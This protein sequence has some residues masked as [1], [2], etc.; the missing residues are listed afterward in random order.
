MR[1]LFCDFSRRFCTVTPTFCHVLLG[2]V[3]CPL[4]EVCGLHRATCLGFVVQRLPRGQGLCKSSTEVA[5]RRTFSVYTRSR[6]CRWLQQRDRPQMCWTK[7]RF[8]GF[9]LPTVM[10]SEAISQNSSRL[11]IGGGL[12]LS[13]QILQMLP[14]LKS[15]LFVV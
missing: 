9:S 4:L 7:R 10:T 12:E 14:S 5:D 1:S 11:E 15:L 6:L 3:T 13:K 8:S 2:V